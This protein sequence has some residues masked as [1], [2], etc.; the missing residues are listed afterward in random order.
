MADLAPWPAGFVELGKLR[1]DTSLVF[2]PSVFLANALAAFAL[3]LVS[4]A[5]GRPL[6]HA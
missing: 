2:Q 1:A 6:Q 3:N 5:L 4:V